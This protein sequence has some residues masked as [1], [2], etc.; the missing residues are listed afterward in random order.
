LAFKYFGFDRHVMK[1]IDHLSW[2][3]LSSWGPLVYF[4]PQT[5]LSN[6][7]V[8]SLSDESYYRSMSCAKIRSL[9]FYYD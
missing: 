2:C 5:W 4:L 9:R 1:V 7:L 6:M 3:W 8:L